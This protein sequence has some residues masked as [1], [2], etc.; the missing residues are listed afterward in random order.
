MNITLDNIDKQFNNRRHDLISM[1]NHKMQV[2]NNVPFAKGREY[3]RNN[4]NLSRST[5]KR[6][7]GPMTLSTLKEKNE[8]NKRVGSIGKRI[9]SAKFDK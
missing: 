6:I 9:K 1:Q 7:M 2:Q 3:K 8:T 5:F 4:S